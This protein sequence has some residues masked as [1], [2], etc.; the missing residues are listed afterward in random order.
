[1]NSF[2]NFLKRNKL[3]AS[4]NIAG[5]TISM[6]FVIL[7][8]IYLVRQFST[9]SFHKNADRIYLIANDE[10]VSMGYWLDKHLKNNFPEIEKG[11]CVSYFGGA[12]RFIIAGEPVYASATAAD[13][14]FFDMFSYELVSGNV[15]DWHISWDRCMVSEDFANAHFPDRNPVGQVIRWTAGEGY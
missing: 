4:V 2:W 14:T 3:Y 7:L 13:S 10:G 9:D 15:L 6:A 5:L 1:M 11:C 12:E 8:S